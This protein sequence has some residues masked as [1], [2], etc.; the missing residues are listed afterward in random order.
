M[1]KNKK[2]II[3]ILIVVL[4]IVIGIVATY[5]LIENN[6]TDRA[7]FNFTVVD[8][9]S[10]TIETVT[11]EKVRSNQDLEEI[12]KYQ[13]ELNQIDQGIKELVSSK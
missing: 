2:I 8:N 6:V 11:Y 1:D 13:E 12:K 7:K 9:N 10:N 4:I 5:K 3:G